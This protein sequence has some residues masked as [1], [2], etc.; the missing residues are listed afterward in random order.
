[1]PYRA[2]F[3]RFEAVLLR[4]GGRPHWAKAH[5]LGPDALRTLY[6]RFDDFVRVLGAADPGGL[7]RNPYVER[8]VFGRT[9]PAVDG[10]VF[11]PVH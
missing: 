2:L 11:K 8:H 9:G 6:P 7:L 10:R 3:S 1:M 5:P 4:H